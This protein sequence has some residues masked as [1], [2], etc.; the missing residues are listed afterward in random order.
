MRV[1]LRLKSD[2][3]SVRFGMGCGNDVRTVKKK[4]LIC[5]KD[6]KNRAFFLVVRW[7]PVS[8]TLGE[9]RG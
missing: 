2:L 4:V 9:R 3:E 7:R 5:R 6:K 1:E 8:R